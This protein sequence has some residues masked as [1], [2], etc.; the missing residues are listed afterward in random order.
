MW[1]EFLERFLVVLYLFY[2]PIICLVFL[3]AAPGYTCRPQSR[4]WH[5]KIGRSTVVPLL[6]WKALNSLILVLKALNL[7]RSQWLMIF[8]QNNALLFPPYVTTNNDQGLCWRSLIQHKQFIMPPPRYFA[9]RS[10]KY[11]TFWRPLTQIFISSR[12]PWIFVI[13]SHKS[14]LRNWLPVLSQFV[15]FLGEKG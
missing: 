4:Y 11:V 15:Q 7:T 1:L 6:S 10:R 8:C 3:L 13:W 12:I 2:H 5:G 9:L 14:V